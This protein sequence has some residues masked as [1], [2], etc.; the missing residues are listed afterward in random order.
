MIRVLRPYPTVLQRSCL[1]ARE[2]D[3]HPPAHSERGSAQELRVITSPSLGYGRNATAY[4]SPRADL[5]QFF[6]N[7]LSALVD[8]CLRNTPRNAPFIS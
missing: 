4:V 6:A 5:P 1:L 2:P 7:K 8:S 3:S